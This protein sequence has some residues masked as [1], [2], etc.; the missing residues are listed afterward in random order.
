MVLII[1]AIIIV[2]Y[3]VIQ[4]IQIRNVYIGKVV[5]ID[6]QNGNADFRLLMWV[7]VK[8]A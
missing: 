8:N 1:G 5:D 3:V 4:T 7:V 2:G 6:F